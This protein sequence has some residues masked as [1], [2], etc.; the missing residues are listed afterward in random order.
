MDPY[1]VLGINHNASE[2]EIKAAYKNM[3]IMT[4]PDKMKGNEM[5]FMMVQAAYKTIKKAVLEKRKQA[6][7]P[8]EK[9]KYKQNVKI[10]ENELSKNFTTAGF[11]QLCEKY[12]DD[13]ARYDPF[14]NGGYKINESLNYQEDVEQ[15]KRAKVKVEKRELVIYKEPE[16]LES[17]KGLENICHL[18][19]HHIEDFTC[20]DG[21]DYKRAYSEEA[22]ILDTRPK[23][24]NIEELKRDRS[25]QSFKLTQEDKKHMKETEY[26]QKQIE[27]L[28]RINVNKT[29]NHYEDICKRM[30]NRL[31]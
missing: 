31:L 20:Q 11:N 17:C 27:Q 15:L 8:K 16:A 10:D 22:E 28:R 2:Q 25:E 30:N 6:N 4:H 9:K 26:K 23:Y 3:C 29:D 7:Y 1:K 18:G 14:M 13:F 21:T 24:K 19:V 5:Y 12:R